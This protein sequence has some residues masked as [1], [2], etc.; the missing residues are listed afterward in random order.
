MSE[1]DEQ[2]TTEAKKNSIG[3]P[4]AD[5]VE[6]VDEFMMDEGNAEAVLKRFDEQHNKYKFMELNLLQKKR[7][8]KKQIPDIKSSLDILRQLKSKQ[9][10]TEEMK[11]HFLLS[12]QVYVKAEV[13]PTDKVFLWLGANVMLEYTLS[14][15]EALLSKNLQKASHNLLQLGEDL[16]F[17]RDQ[18][19]TTEVN[20]ARVY[21]WDV[22]R[23][24]AEREKKQSS[25]TS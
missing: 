22:K 21:N 8:L 18:L 6:N 5:F 20:M 4:A 13:P 23:R 3:I 19:T 2:Q 10:A 17:L 1:L 7:R 9:E 11:T 16:D 15:A 12:D 24:Q 25:S 14:D